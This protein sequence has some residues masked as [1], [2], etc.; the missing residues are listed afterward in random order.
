MRGIRRLRPIR[1][2]R[3]IAG[4]FAV[5]RPDPPLNPNAPRH[6]S[7]AASGGTATACGLQSKSCPSSRA[8]NR[9]GN[10]TAAVTLHA[11]VRQSAVL[12][13]RRATIMS[14]VTVAGA[15]LPFLVL[16]AQFGLVGLSQV[17][18]VLDR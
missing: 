16:H 12:V 3:A 11:I 15:K 9:R 2:A 5:T 7:P 13:T 8:K 10:Y 17:P 14:T 4:G 18:P 6:I 1:R